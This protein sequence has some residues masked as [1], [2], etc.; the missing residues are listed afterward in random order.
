MFLEGVPHSLEP[1]VSFSFMPL[2]SPFLI[3]SLW[4]FTALQWLELDYTKVAICFQLKYF[5]GSLQWFICIVSYS[6]TNY[7]ETEWLETHT[8]YLTV[9]LAL[10]Q[11]FRGGL[12]ER[13]QIRVFY[14]VMMLAGAAVIWRL[15]CAWRI[16]MLHGSL[17]R[18][19]DKSLSSLS[20][21][22]SK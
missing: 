4:T 7:I 3:P 11:E 22:L 15:N 17:P 19:L 14:E 20:V 8:Y 5:L 9:S 6:I 16:H 1:E 2:L 13:S 10:G 18:L 21:S 12:L